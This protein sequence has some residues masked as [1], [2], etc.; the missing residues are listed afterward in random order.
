M[1]RTHWIRSTIIALVSS[2]LAGCGASS[3]TES[4]TSALES[5]SAAPVQEDT[6]P[7]E[8][9]GVARWVDQRGATSRGVVLA[10]GTLA[11]VAGRRVLVDPAGKVVFVGAEAAPLTALA[12]VR[13]GS[14]V[15]VVGLAGNQVWR[16]DDVRG[17]GR[18]IA[19]LAEQPNDLRRL[20]GGTKL[21]RIEQGHGLPEVWL[22]LDGKRVSPPT[23]PLPEPTPKVPAGESPVLRW[24]DGERTSPLIAAVVGG[25]RVGPNRALVASG[26]DLF[27][28]DLDTGLPVAVKALGIE[29]HATRLT[30]VRSGN[31]GRLAYFS[32]HEPR[33][34]SAQ[35]PAGALFAVSWPSSFSGLSEV[36]VEDLGRPSGAAHAASVSSSGGV[37]WWHSCTEGEVPPRDKVARGQFYSFCVRQ[38]DGSFKTVLTSGAPS[39]GDIL[40]TPTSDGGLVYIAPVGQ[41]EGRASLAVLRFDSE[42]NP[43]IV[44]QLP[45][46]VAMRRGLEALGSNA[47][48]GFISVFKA[49]GDIRATEETEF[50]RVVDG[51][52]STTP[53]GVQRSRTWASDG[54]HAAIAQEGQYRVTTNGGATWRGIE[55]PSLRRKFDT[56]LVVGELG[57]AEDGHVRLGWAEAIEGKLPV[58]EERLAETVDSRSGLP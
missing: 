57:L 33:G 5:A 16:F 43:S 14:S 8:I 54:A 29:G 17:P 45:H 35:P 25:V 44:A 51:K 38:P 12:L 4:S 47:F 6:P 11:L 40:P 9:A 15:T 19:V 37:V 34:K 18:R 7:E 13:D 23:E 22:D 48:T 50:L 53:F 56:P 41:T 27:E 24:V 20:A 10:E 2:A 42:S 32:T 39:G 30:R 58:E 52:V 3:A 1:K 36:V 49:K 21:L 55:R 31:G 28:V 46:E 26:A